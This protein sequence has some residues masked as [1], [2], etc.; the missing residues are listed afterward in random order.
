MH[1]DIDKLDLAELVDRLDDMEGKRTPAGWEADSAVERS[2]VERRIM[3]LVATN[4]PEEERRKMLRIPCELEV[5]LKSKTQSVRAQ[6]RDIG[7]GGV[8]VQT[9]KPFPVGTPVHV[10]VR[11][12]SDEHGLRVRGEVSWI[13]AGASG[14]G[15]GVAFSKPDSDGH[16]RRLRRF[17]IELLRHRVGD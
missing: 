4:P 6:A 3:E 17:V 14:A 16:E 5:K 11:Q 2:A 7:I 13:A 10:E 9:S 8:F 15:V 1:P 12:G